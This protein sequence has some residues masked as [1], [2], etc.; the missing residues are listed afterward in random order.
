MAV[1]QVRTTP[2]LGSLPTG[3]KVCSYW[4]AGR[5][6]RRPCRFLH[7]EPPS[8]YT[9]HPKVKPLPL[10]KGRGPSKMLG[11]KDRLKP[12]ERLCQHWASGT[13][14]RGD[15]CLFQHSWSRG[16]GFG[17]L[18]KLVGHEKVI[19]FDCSFMALLL[20]TCFFL[21]RWVLRTF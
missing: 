2:R 9:C 11:R 13:C 14:A 16:E 7:M 5:C 3:S 4:L 6:T 20:F 1:K 18:A 12:Y 8:Q 21:L 15:K 19:Y 17:L 10:P